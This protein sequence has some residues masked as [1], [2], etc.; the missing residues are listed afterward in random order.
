MKFVQGRACGYRNFENYRL[1]VLVEYGGFNPDFLFKFSLTTRVSVDLQFP[2]SLKRKRPAKSEPFI[3]AI[4]CCLV[5]YP[6]PD[7]NRY[8]LADNRF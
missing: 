7:S 5:K 1:R 6:R 8:V 3:Y 4:Y 2:H